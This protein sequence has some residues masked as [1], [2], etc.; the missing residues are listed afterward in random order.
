MYEDVDVAR[1]LLAM[2]G[3][4]AQEFS[5]VGALLGTRIGELAGASDAFQFADGRAVLDENE[6]IVLYTLQGA[7]EEPLE[8]RR[9]SLRRGWADVTSRFTEVLGAPSDSF[10]WGADAWMC[11][12]WRG[13]HVVLSVEESFYDD[14]YGAPQLL[15]ACV[16]TNDEALASREGLTARL[17][18][19]PHPI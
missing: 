16:G 7:E 17:V 9:A 3:I 14:S 18:R 19:Q 4:D 11:S 8:R 5:R 12:V 1:H 15:L 2:R 10:S 6:R 13:P